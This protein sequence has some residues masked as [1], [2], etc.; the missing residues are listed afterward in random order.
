MPERMYGPVLLMVAF[1]GAVVL[2]MV[3]LSPLIFTSIDVGSSTEGSTIDQVFIQDA[4]WEQWE[5]NIFTVTDSAQSNGYGL[6]D[7]QCVEFDAL[8]G[9]EHPLQ[10]T[11][12]RNATW[13]WERDTSDYWYLWQTYGWLGAERASELLS[14]DDIE[15]GWD[16]EL[17]YSM[18]ILD[19]RYTFKMLIWVDNMTDSE[20]FRDRLDNNLYNIS[21]GVSVNDTIDDISPWTM[22]G[23]I[24]TFRMPGTNIVTNALIAIPIYTALLY[25]AFAIIRSVIPL[26]G[27]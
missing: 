8:G 24:M 18:V 7:D 5:P 20:N 1:F 6:E 3:L 17:N 10:C 9:S 11:L 16:G 13:P 19:M 25:I 27:G 21:V 14:L 4:N 22:L 26:L 23:K 2:L 15:S 12:V